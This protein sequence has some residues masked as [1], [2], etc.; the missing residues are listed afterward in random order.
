MKA[1]GE[2]CPKGHDC[3][4]VVD[5]GDRHY[6]YCYDCKKKYFDEDFD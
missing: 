2:L 4:D 6:M 1:K 3:V 5:F